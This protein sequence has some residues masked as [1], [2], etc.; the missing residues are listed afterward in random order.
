MP[1]LS[2][3]MLQSL[4]LA[5][6]LASPVL[7]QAPAQPTPTEKSNSGVGDKAAEPKDVDKGQNMILPSAGSAGPSAA[8]TMVYDCQKKPEDCR[9]PATPADKAGASEN[10]PIKP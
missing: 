7:A 9:T 5:A 6:F 10:K 1:S 8:P 2:S 3:T 4:A